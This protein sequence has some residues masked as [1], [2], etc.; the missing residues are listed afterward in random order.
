[1]VL[2]EYQDPEVLRCT[3]EYFIKLLLERHAI[4]AA[5]LNP[6]GSVIL[7]GVTAR[8]DESQHYSSI[9]GNT[10]H[11][12][13]LEAEAV[14]DSLPKGQ[15]EALYQWA[16]GMTSLE[17]SQWLGVK[18]DA[19]RKRRE[20]GLASAGRQWK[21]RHDIPVPDEEAVEVA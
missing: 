20:R 17:S 5:L 18:P 14:V 8:T 11:L 4:R 16:D 21:T 1:M 10:L 7:T 13:L 15:R 19:I 12:D 2:Q 6:G 3:T 9:M